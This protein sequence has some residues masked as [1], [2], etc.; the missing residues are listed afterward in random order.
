MEKEENKGN[1]RCEKLAALYSDYV[2]GELAASDRQ[3][4]EEH[5]KGC[6]SCRIDIALM[7]EITRNLLMVEEEEV[8]V[9]FA[10]SVAR[11]AQRTGAPGQ[12]GLLER[13]GEF[14]GLWR[15]AAVGAMAVVV[16]FLLLPHAGLLEGPGAAP[17]VAVAV[18]AGP[19]IDAQGAVT[20]AS[21]PVSGLTE[22]TP[23]QTIEVG[24]GGRAVLSYVNDTRVEA[25][26]G[27]RLACLPAGVR[28]E[29][30]KVLVSV[31]RK[32]P[33]E[34]VPAYQVF[35][36]NAV[37]SVWGTRFSVHYDGAATRVECTEGVV[38]VQ[39]LQDGRAG[40][41]SRIAA[42]QVATVTAAAEVAVDKLTSQ[43]A[44]ASGP[45]TSPEDTTLP[46]GPGSVLHVPTGGK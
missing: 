11:E 23:A 34:G 6:A 18:P 25:V 28:L 31:P 5:L 26:P 32:A 17:G 22:V 10:A 9:D 45:A 20:L 14:A 44:E 40:S 19:R 42:G 2:D 33:R 43:P 21:R 29:G 38:G 3:L 7:R 46:M 8:P 27:S 13:L 16:A 37:V 15:V 36:P 30:G 39:K 12:V 41:E 24:D 4:V 1:R 35:T